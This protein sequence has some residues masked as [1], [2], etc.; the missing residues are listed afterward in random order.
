MLPFSLI[1]TLMNLESFLQ[2]LMLFCAI[3]IG[4]ALLPQRVTKSCPAAYSASPK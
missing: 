3:D 1:F 2:K 4:L